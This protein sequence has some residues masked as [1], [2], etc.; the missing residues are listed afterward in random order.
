M[1]PR[2]ENLKPISEPLEIRMLLTAQAVQAGN[3]AWLADI[4]EPQLQ[5]F[6][7]QSESWLAPIVPIVLEGATGTSGLCCRS[8]VLLLSA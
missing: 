3:V 7:L 5:R 6:D 2:R 8:P 1:R 4:N